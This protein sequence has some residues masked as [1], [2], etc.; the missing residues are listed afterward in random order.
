M[1]K[2]KNVFRVQCLKPLFS[3]HVVF[4]STHIFNKLFERIRTRTFE[5][6]RCCSF[7]G[8]SSTTKDKLT[9]D[10]SIVGEDPARWEGLFEVRTE[11]N[12]EE[13][14]KMIIRPGAKFI[15]DT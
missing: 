12:F 13:T 3:F 8:L 1:R 9:V 15:G 11:F 2:R 14:S 7:T 6:K 5:D 4:F 10:A